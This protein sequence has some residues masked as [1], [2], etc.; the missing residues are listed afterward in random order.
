[1]AHV[2][3]CV[4]NISEGRRKDVVDAVVAALRPTGVRVLDVQSDKD[5]NRSVLTLAGDEASLE[6]GVKYLILGA[7]SSAFMVYG[8]ALV[9]GTSGKFNFSDLAMVAGKF[10]DNKVFLFGVL[11]RR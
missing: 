1:M 7:L 2:I 4:P 9:W 11:F 8:I 6:A 5:H 10:G 3:E